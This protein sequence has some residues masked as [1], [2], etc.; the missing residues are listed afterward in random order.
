MESVGKAA[1]GRD[2]ASAKSNLLSYFHSR[3]NGDVKRFDALSGELE[4]QVIE[5]AESLLNDPKFP[6]VDLDNDHESLWYFLHYFEQAHR[7]TGD[8][9]FLNAWLGIFNE[10]Y[11]VSRPPAQKPL[12]YIGFIWMRDWS[13]LVACSR[14]SAF[15]RVERMLRAEPGTE[16][17]RSSRIN[18]YKSILEQARF[19]AAVNDTFLPSNW[20]IHQMHSLLEVSVLFPEYRESENWKELAW[21]RL[22]EHMQWETMPDGGHIERA[23]GYNLGVIKSYRI[24]VQIAEEAGITI[25]GW[26]MEK[27]EKM[28]EWLMDILLPGLNGPP[29]GDG[30]GFGRELHFNALTYGALKFQRSHF[31]WFVQDKP[32]EVRSVAEKWFDDPDKVMA[33][34]RSVKAEK[35]GYDSVLLPDTGW[36]VMRSSRESDALAL[37]L[38]YGSNE[39]FHTHADF[40]SFC[41][42][43]CGEPLILD[44]GH[45]GAYESD[46]SKLWYKKTISHNTVM[47][48]RQSQWR[49]MYGECR[50]WVSIND[51][52]YIDTYNSGYKTI[53]IYHWRRILFVK[54]EFWIVTDFLNRGEQVVTSGYHEYDWLA[55]F[56]ET[57]I[58]I[59]H[60]T[61]KTNTMNTGANA[62][63]VPMNPGE[64]TVTR[65]K[66]PGVTARGERDD[67][68]YI[69]LHQEHMP[70]AYFGVILYPYRGKEKPDIKVIEL[71]TGP[72]DNSAG[73]PP[74]KD[75][76]PKEHRAR[77]P[78]G[79]RIE[80]NNGTYFYL[81]SDMDGVIKYGDFF[82]NGDMAFLK[83]G[84][85]DG[86]SQLFIVNGRSLRKDE[87]SL[88]ESPS[89][90]DYVYIQKERGVIS[91]ESEGLKE[92]AIYAPEANKVIRNKKQ[93]EFER[94]GEYVAIG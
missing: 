16:A 42:Y 68:P 38:D 81:E 20:Q 91:I 57:D 65:S 15:A 77:S 64:I 12:V 14:I 48:D 63:V 50:K 46:R 78:R 75:P 84:T 4:E 60:K 73:V 70:P 59:D 1:A 32:E 37:I 10:W 21:L 17:D 76:L 71:E 31:K 93:I 18:L 26:F 19:L 94:R 35:P 69:A 58:Q 54:P 24:A 33:E 56:Q 62:A 53:G 89:D 25:P 92:A 83:Q 44:S 29:I 90:V 47:V 67:I 45:T 2:F 80:I 22:K 36:A 11:H 66:G 86:C 52:D 34:Y 87:R 13:T 82:F 55:H 6:C 30:G 72:E 85:E 61:K 79:F 51:F 49:A 9:R 39:P 8:S 74:Y 41:M 27:F 43:A 7:C 88:F 23:A 40:G 28:H 3:G 5:K